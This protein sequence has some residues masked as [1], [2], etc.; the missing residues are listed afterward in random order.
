MYLIRGIEEEMPREK[1]VALKSFCRDLG[2]LAGAQRQK[3]NRAF[4]H[5]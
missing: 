4:A 3:Q 2:A 5:R 1:V